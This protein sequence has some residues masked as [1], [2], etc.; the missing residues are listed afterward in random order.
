MTFSKWVILTN[1]LFEHFVVVAMPA[2]HHSPCIK[3]QLIGLINSWICCTK[4]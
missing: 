3:N 2:S 1:D 4:K